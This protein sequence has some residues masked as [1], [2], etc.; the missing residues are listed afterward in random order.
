MSDI[1]SI[2]DLGSGPYPL[3]TGKEKPLFS[4]LFIF[5]FFST[6]RIVKCPR[7]PSPKWGKERESG[8]SRPFFAFSCHLRPI[9]IDPK[10]SRIRKRSRKYI[11]GFFLLFLREFFAREKL[12][13]RKR[14]EVGK[15]AFF[16]SSL[17]EERNGAGKKGKLR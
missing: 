11:S 7:V 12:G 4:I 17:F 1:K 14:Y 2:Y 15:T 3:G 8:K 10:I 13:L 16:L 9:T 5:L 6:G